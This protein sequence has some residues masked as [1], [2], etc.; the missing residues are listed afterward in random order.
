VNHIIDMHLLTKYEGGLQSLYDVE[1]YT[2][3]WLE[4][5]M[6]IALTK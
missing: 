3:M 2:L 5:T 1:Y 6:T 4:T